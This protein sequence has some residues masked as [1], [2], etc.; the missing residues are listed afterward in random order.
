MPG[1]IY[2]DL[3]KFFVQSATATCTRESVL[4]WGCAEFSFGQRDWQWV[5][6]GLRHFQDLMQRL[7]WLCSFSARIWLEQ[8]VGNSV[9]VV[10]SLNLTKTERMAI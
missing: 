1:D 6:L 8:V 7:W 10:D 5:G 4:G 2:F 3:F 9:Q